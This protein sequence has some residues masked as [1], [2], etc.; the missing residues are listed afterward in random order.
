MTQSEQFAVVI[1]SI[2]TA[3]PD[4]AVAVARGL[5]LSPDQTLRAIYR[6]PVVLA[7]ALSVSAARKLCDLLSSL[8]FQT[9]LTEGTAV[10]ALPEPVLLDVALH[11]EE[12][13]QTLLVAAELAKFCGV[14]VADALRLITDPPGIVLGGV[15]QA[16]VDALHRRVANMG[17]TLTASNPLTA[18]FDLF[19]TGLPAT[20]TAQLR[21]ELAEAERDLL[22]GDTLIATGLPHPLADR[23]WRKYGRSGSVRMIDQ[24]FLRFDL[25][26]DGLLPGKTVRDSH[27][28]L[29]VN[30]FGM[31]PE[32][33]DTV[34]AELPI[35]LATNLAYGSFEESLA[36]LA[37]AGLSARAVLATFTPIALE[38]ESA[39]DSQAVASELALLGLIDGAVTLPFV[40]PTM[41]PALARMARARIEAAGGEVF[42]L[43]CAA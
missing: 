20:V 5:G 18:Q 2:G 3:S 7:S 25:V 28:E 26:L 12:P 22:E 23:L 17:A 30:M 16:S 1:D 4:Q 38:V 11:V 43:D 34:M 39:Q 24:A 40:T 41:A 42:L 21:R 35:T 10:N 36:K 13:I 37:A 27:A 9:R 19:A 15:T 6:A 8:G 29:L 14:E 31:P 33:F 32:L